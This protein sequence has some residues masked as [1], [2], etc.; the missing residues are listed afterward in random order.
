MLKSVWLVVL[1]ALVGCSDPPQRQQPPRALKSCNLQCEKWNIAHTHLAD[2]L[3]DGKEIISDFTFSIG[4]HWSDK[5]DDW[6]CDCGL[7]KHLSLDTCV[8]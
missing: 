1:A 4:V 3:P 2:P 5:D 7:T 6:I 8:R